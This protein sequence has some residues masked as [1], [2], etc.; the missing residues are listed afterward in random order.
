MRQET[1]VFAQQLKD[2]RPPNSHSMKIK[3][4]PAS[5]KPSDQRVDPGPRPRL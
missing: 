4:N 2:P 5:I 1:G 3:V